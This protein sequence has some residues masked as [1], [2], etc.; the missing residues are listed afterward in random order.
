M[1]INKTNLNNSILGRE[2]TYFLKGKRFVGDKVTLVRGFG[3]LVCEDV[4]LC[5]VSYV[6]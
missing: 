4:C 2:G 1:R 3:I 6:H 5:Y